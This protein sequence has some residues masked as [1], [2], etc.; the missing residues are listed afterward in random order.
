ML[1]MGAG[2]RASWR[3]HR[4]AADGVRPGAEG[5]THE[6][7]SD[8]VFATFAEKPSVGVDGKGEACREAASLTLVLGWDTSTPEAFTGA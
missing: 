1:G 4:Q 8:V 7:T 6:E 2:N 5:A 3:A